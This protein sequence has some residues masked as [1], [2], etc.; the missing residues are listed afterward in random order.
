MLDVAVTFITKS[1]NFFNSEHSMFH[2][3]WLS[4]LLQY[5]HTAGYTLSDMWL[6]AVSAVIKQRSFYLLIIN[7]NNYQDIIV[8]ISIICKAYFLYTHANVL[9]N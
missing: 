7:Y 6:S 9:Q 2:R 3:I 5:N 4:L 1:T 8:I